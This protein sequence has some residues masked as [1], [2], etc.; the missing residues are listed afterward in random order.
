MG[1]LKTHEEEDQVVPLTPIS[2][3][4]VEGGTLSSLWMK[5]ITIR[6]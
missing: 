2:N 5:R 1:K 6:E 3:P 4:R